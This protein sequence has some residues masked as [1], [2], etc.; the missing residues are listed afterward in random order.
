MSGMV[1]QSKDSFLRTVNEMIAL[2][3]ENIAIYK[4]GAVF[5]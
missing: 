3:P 4:N 1:G 5:E 2:E